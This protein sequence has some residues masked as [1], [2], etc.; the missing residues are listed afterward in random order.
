MKTT[1]K[2]HINPINRDLMI[3]FFTG[4]LMA[5]GLVTA[6]ILLISQL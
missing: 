2:S 5:I 3:I 6:G 1:T 4:L